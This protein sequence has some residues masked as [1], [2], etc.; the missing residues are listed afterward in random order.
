MR[1]DH[2]WTV[3]TINGINTPL[4]VLHRS[5]LETSNSAPSIH[6]SPMNLSVLCTSLTNVCSIHQLPTYPSPTNLVLHTCPGPDLDLKVAKNTSDMVSPSYT[7]IKIHN[8]SKIHIMNFCKQVEL[9]WPSLLSPIH[10]SFL[11][12]IV[13]SV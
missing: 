10:L 5:K 6:P 8:K 9:K 3:K 12:L 7:E 13:S 2:C 1:E 11:W 4:L